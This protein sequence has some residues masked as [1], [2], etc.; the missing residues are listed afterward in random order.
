[1]KPPKGFA[2]IAIFSTLILIA[3]SIAACTTSPSG[4]GNTP[5]PPSFANTSPANRPILVTVNSVDRVLSLAN[6]TMGKGRVLL[7]LNV[8]VANRDTQKP[9]GFPLTGHSFVLVD[10]ASG[11]S[12][13]LFLVKPSLQAALENPL[14]LPTTVGKQDS[15]TGDIVFGIPDSRE[16]RLDLMAPGGNVITSQAITMDSPAASGGALDVTIYSV[17]KRWNLKNE[18]FP[19][20][21]HV[22]VVLNISVKNTG[23]PQGFQFVEESTTLED[24]VSGYSLQGSFNSKYKNIPHEL[25]DPILLPITLQL[26]SVVRGQLLFSTRDS[27]EYRLNFIDSNKTVLWSGTVHAG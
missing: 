4:T 26:N 2:A 18:S 20:G 15:V 17:E 23:L 6:I 1:M 11:T 7:I 25:E 10:P 19:M 9:G 14:P 24:T 27:T 22:F 3:I 21:G 16:Y 8:T 13:P 12:V 5:P